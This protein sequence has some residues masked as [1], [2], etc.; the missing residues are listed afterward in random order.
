MQQT[1]YFYVCIEATS[2]F[3]RGGRFNV[4]L[5]LDLN[6][7]T[8]EN[9]SAKNSATYIKFAVIIM[10]I[11]SPL[12]FYFDN[13]PYMT[14]TFD[15]W[16]WISLFL[17]AKCYNALMVYQNSTKSKTLIA[18]SLQTAKIKNWSIKCI[19]K[20]WSDYSNFMYIY[21]EN[22]FRYKQECYVWY[23]CKKTNFLLG[24]TKC[25]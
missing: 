1:L 19:G 14:S 5:T 24:H 23:L 16:P 12:P 25:R 13:D 20:Q 21:F 6:L 17:P 4:S 8:F 9:L 22:H 15:G 18:S 3:F 10:Y 7:T 2:P 11:R